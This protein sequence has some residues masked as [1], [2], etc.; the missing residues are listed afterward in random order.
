M[1]IHRI[2][3][4]TSIEEQKRARELRGLDEMQLIFMRLIGVTHFS[5]IE[6][7]LS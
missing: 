3:Y 5:E 4:P 7:V 1:G 2:I 6:R